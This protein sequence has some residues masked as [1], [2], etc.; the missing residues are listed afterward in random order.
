MTPEQ[1]AARHSYLYHVTS[2]DAW[3]SI[4]RH[5][6]RST[7]SLLDLF[8]VPAEMCH[9]VTTRRRTTEISVGHPVHGRATIHDNRPLSEAALARCLDDGL[10]PEDWLALLNQ[11]VFFWVDHDGVDSLLGARTN[12]RRSRAVLVFDTL[13][14][15]RANADRV[16]VSPINSGS[17]IRKPARRG[18]T[19][20]TPLLPMDYAAWRRQ[21]G[22]L[23]RVRE[24]V[25]VGDVA[26]VAN[27]LVDCWISEPRVNSRID[28]ASRVFSSI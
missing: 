25:V 16:E 28:R 13:R 12:R 19:T 4:E 26:D 17:T 5:G 20:F 22:R 6:L 2:P 1:L 11:R 18:S 7:K 8:E 24:V 3:P 14:L 15:V 27:H 21:R 9:E 23:D 10:R